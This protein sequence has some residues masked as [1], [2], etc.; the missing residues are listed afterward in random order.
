[1][2]LANLERQSYVCYLPQTHIERVR[3]RKAG[4]AAE[5]MFLR[6]LLVQLDSHD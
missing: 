5:P 4:V 1:M 2:A 3:R 6:Y